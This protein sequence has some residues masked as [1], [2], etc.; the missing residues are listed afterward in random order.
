MVAFI[1][2]S[3]GYINMDQV[4]QV[5]WGQK[6]ETKDRLQ[7]YGPSGHFLCFCS[8]PEDIKVVEEWLECNSWKGKPKATAA[9]TDPRWFTEKEEG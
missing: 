7:F 3:T 9:P 4:G 2:T 5:G 6:E 1:K 8:I